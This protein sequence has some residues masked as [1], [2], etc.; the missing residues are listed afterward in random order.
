MVITERNRNYL[1][2]VAARHN[3]ITTVTA[4]MCH[5]FGDTFVTKV[6]TLWR[7][8]VTCLLL[9]AQNEGLNC[10]RGVFILLRA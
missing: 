9:D 7:V 5:C 8:K 6:I 10:T 4:V 3:D 1:T 2:F